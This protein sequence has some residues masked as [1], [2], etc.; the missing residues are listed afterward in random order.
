MSN[1]MFVL[2]L[3]VGAGALAVWVEVR[4]PSF[5]P[6]RLGGTMLHAVL[7]FGLLMFTSSAGE[8]ITITALFLSLLPALIYALLCTIWVLRVAQT[9]LGLSR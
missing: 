7:A 1:G 4:F 3:T 8:T 9:A 5:A 6:A 2:A